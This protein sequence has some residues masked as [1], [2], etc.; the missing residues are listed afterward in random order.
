MKVYKVLEHKKIMKIAI[1]G[2]VHGN[3]N[4]MYSN[5]LEIGANLK[6]EIDR[7]YQLGE[8]HAIR[9]KRDLNR[10]HAPLK[11]RAMGSFHNYY[12]KGI[13]PM[14]TYL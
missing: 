14:D 1:V 12:E 7:I 2:D 8:F 10:F 11:H 13:E 5:I 9:D 4:K 3:I 6:E